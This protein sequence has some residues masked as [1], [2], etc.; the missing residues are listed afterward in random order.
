[1][2]RGT[3]TTAATPSSAPIT[4]RSETSPPARPS[5]KLAI[6]I[7][8]ATSASAARKAPILRSRLR[9]ELRLRARGEVQVEDHEERQRA[10][11][12]HGERGAERVVLLLEERPLDDVADEVDAP[13]AEDQRDHVLPHH[14]D[15]HEQ[16]PGDQAGGGEPQRDLAERRPLR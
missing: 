10:H 11:H 4:P 14:R 6:A 16:R 12:E 5:R 2:A 8:P 9:T 1:M 3:S 7:T 15:E 13:A